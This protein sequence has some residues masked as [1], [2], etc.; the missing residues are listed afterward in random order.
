M[1]QLVLFFA[2]M[3][4]LANTK[5]QSI[6]ETYENSPTASTVK[7]T[8]AKPALSLRLGNGSATIITQKFLL[9]H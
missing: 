9:H 5:A 6:Y 3:F 1:K 4:I 7:Q 2:F 8:V